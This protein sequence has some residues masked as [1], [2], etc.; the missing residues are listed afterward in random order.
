[1]LAICDYTCGG[2]GVHVISRKRLK[3]FWEK[4]PDAKA[5]LEAWFKTAKKAN[6]RNITEVRQ[7]YRH[8]DAVGTCTVFNIRQ[9]RFRLVAKIAYR[10]QRV[11][12]KQVLTHAEYDRGEWKHGCR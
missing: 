10:I 9:N 11:Y 2:N 12:I 3:E 8:A 7:S 6:W 1:M 5:D 4:N